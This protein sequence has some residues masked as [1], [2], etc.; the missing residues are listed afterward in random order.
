MILEKETALNKVLHNSGLIC[1]TTILK[2]NHTFG[3][4][5]ILNVLLIWYF[6]FFRILLGSWVSCTCQEK[7]LWHAEASN[8]VK[9]LVR[10]VFTSGLILYIILFFKFST[11]SMELIVSCNYCFLFI[12]QTIIISKT[13]TWNF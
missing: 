13:I 3:R 6:T 12:C 8:V 2:I 1:L 4:G 5:S 11:S 10:R 7:L 9:L